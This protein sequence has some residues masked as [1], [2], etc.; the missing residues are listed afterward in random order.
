MSRL[1]PASSDAS[2]RR[3][4][5]VFTDRGRYVAMDAPPEK[6][7]CG[8]FVRIAGYLDAV[9]VNA[10]R[11]VEAQPA[12]GFLLLTDLG[13]KRY[14]E[15]LKAAPGRARALYADALDALVRMQQEGKAYQT[16]LPPY[17]R[18]L[19]DREL[20]LFR[21]WLC[22]RHLGLAFN[23][24]DEAAWRTTRRFLVAEALSQ[25]RVFVHRDYHSRNLMVCDDNP[26]ILDFQDAVEGPYTYDLVSLL[27]D[28]YV[29]WPAT[30][31]RELAL[32][33]FARIGASLPGVPDEDGFL[34]DFDLMGVQRHLKAAGI[35]ARLDHRD[36]KP[37]YLA[38]IPR[39]LG[40]VT[41]L[42]GRYPELDFLTGLI[43]E[44]CLPGLGGAVGAAS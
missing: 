24:A 25:P 8:P 27:E 32:G 15:V 44:R 2:F 20:A 3:Y 14:L 30:M 31:V 16:R 35:F 23:A 11:I 42:A 21:G 41:A 22:D 18:A 4:F 43:E 9:G 36:G 28:C 34:R 1:E 39:T 5:R 17:D 38:D 37:A 7:D 13:E 33:F 10:P 6:E 40:Y 12:T 29:R 19:L 26:G